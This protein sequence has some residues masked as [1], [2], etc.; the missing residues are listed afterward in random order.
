MRYPYGG[1][2]DLA[3]LSAEVFPGSPFTS[4][5][6][7]RPQSTKKS[8][9]PT[10]KPD[11]TSKKRS[12]TQGTGNEEG[13]GDDEEKKRSRGRPRLDVKDESAAD[14]RRTQIRLAQRAYRNR[15][16][17]AIAT[18]ENQVRELKDTNEEMS[19]A[20]MQLHDF[21]TKNGLLDKIPEFGRQLRETTQKFLSLAQS[22]ND[23]GYD[24]HQAA[25][26]D[27]SSTPG[28][29]KS[30]P[31]ETTTTTPDK[32]SN[33]QLFAGIV[34]THEP[35][36]QPDF[37]S[38]FSTSF[39]PPTTTTSV[40]GYEIV[41]HPTIENA[42]FAFQP[43][44]TLNLF[45]F[46]STFPYNQLSL[47]KSLSAHEGTFGRRL[48]RFAIE[49]A[50]ILIT[51]PSPPQAKLDRVFGFCLLFETFDTIRR[52]LERQMARN[53]QEALNNW[54][55]PF[56]NLG[57][58]GTH[59][60]ATT[61]TRDHHHKFGNQGTRDVMK[62]SN[63]SGYGTGPFS[64]EVNGVRD[65][66]LDKNMHMGEPGFGGEFL[67]CDEV[68]IYLY[69]RG[70]VIPPGTDYVTVD[71]DPS[72]FD[73]TQ[74]ML[75]DTDPFNTVT[76]QNST[77]VSFYNNPFSQQ[78]VST[79]SPSPGASSGTSS[80]LNNPS[81]SHQSENNWNIPVSSSVDPSLSGAFSL[82]GSYL[83]Q[84]IASGSQADILGGMFTS[85]SNTGSNNPL[86]TSGFDQQPPQRQSQ[87][88]Q[89]VYFDVHEFVK[90]VV[91]TARCLGRTA[92][93][94]Q[95]DVNNAFWKASQVQL[96]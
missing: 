79:A 7:K 72:H 84:T 66:S 67:D 12:R 70:V 46:Q 24:Q 43:D 59:Y 69:Q 38:N 50:Y 15:K 49:R 40:L 89:R 37:M 62:P 57:G 52:R 42:S 17:N 61:D 96:S 88:K 95:A 48:Q 77:G 18:L 8:P 78:T 16:E 2:G 71:I 28:R 10:K 81:P 41:A 55:F 32:T 13:V 74:P 25:G 35:I 45:D 22:A 19:N 4:N 75:V 73:N 5:P 68:E 86:L 65:T 1:G 63:S 6:S 33:P 53:G 39:S 47:P 92:G 56:L 20:F 64:A 87:R 85:F 76:Q 29:D 54:E 34:V 26:S 93:F 31:P 80:T 91:N 94:K 21:A 9:P 58:A 30:S 14:R 23:Q 44:P 3:I 27:H 82:A 11:T 90:S 51:M 60:D 36:T 83:A